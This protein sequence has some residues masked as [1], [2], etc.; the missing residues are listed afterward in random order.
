MTKAMKNRYYYS[1]NTERVRTN[2]FQVAK[3]ISSQPQTVKNSIAL[4]QIAVLTYSIQKSIPLVL[5]GVTQEMHL[6]YW[7]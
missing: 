3:L 1:E 2:S 4:L 5:C 7:W 6:A